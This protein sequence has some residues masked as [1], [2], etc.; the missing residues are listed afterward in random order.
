MSLLQTWK[1]AGERQRWDGPQ[2]N[3]EVKLTLKVD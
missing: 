1:A 2:I 3:E